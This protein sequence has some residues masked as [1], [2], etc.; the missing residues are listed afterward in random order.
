MPRTFPQHW[1]YDSVAATAWFVFVE[2]G[3]NPFAANC[4][5][6]LKPCLVPLGDLSV[7]CRF[8]FNDIAILADQ[9]L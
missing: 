4:D 3:I 5:G 2:L 6:P 9:W 8:D 1:P 7:D